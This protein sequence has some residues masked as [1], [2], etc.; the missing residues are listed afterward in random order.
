MKS[1][2]GV[3]KLILYHATEKDNISKIVKA[4]DFIASSSDHEWLANGVYFWDNIINAEWWSETKGFK[5]NRA[6]YKCIVKCEGSKYLDLDVLEN[7]VAYNDFVKNFYLNY[8]KNKEENDKKT[9]G[10]NLKNKI[11]ARKFFINLLCKQNNIYLVKRTFYYNN[12]EH[13]G[14]L[15]TPR[16]QYCVIDGYQGKLIKEME[17]LDYEEI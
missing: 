15:E 8:S 12:K 3:K 11:K 7:T 5:D 6:F 4:S 16:T 14:L 10:V 2:I 9:K 1:L 17:V 13:K